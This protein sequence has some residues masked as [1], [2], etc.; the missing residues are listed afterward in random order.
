[1]LARQLHTP[2][3]EIEDMD[4]DRF[5]AYSQA[6]VRIQKAEAPKKPGKKK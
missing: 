2:I 4:W 5:D 3:S 1:M 6:M